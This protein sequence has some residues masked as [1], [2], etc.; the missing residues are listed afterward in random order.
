MSESSKNQWDDVL[1]EEIKN[2]L[3]KEKVEAIRAT[4]FV[5][6]KLNTDAERAIK[7][8]QQ[9]CGLDFDEAGAI[10][11]MVHRSKLI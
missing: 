9:K 6:F 7:I 11:D 1:S 3:T 8:L 5:I 4:S 2:E 10:Y